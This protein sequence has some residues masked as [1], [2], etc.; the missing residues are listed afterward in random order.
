MAAKQNSMIPIVSKN[1]CSA[2]EVVLGVRMRP[3]V[4]NGGG[5]VVIDVT[6]K[7]VFRVDG[8]GVIGKKEQLLLRDGDGNELLLI[9][10][11]GGI[12]EAL[13]LHKRW[14]GYSHDL[15]G[16][17]KLVFSL[18]EPKNSYSCMGKNNRITVSVA[19]EYSA[20]GEFAI[21]GEFAA[22]DCYI[23]N[24]NGSVIAQVSIYDSF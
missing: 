20:Y 10:R 24:S 9:R 15:E 1:F 5:F 14:K 4:V 13:S 17:E 18:K 16:S 8:C 22:R 6:Q 21:T 7:V 11:K 2:S 19:S 12:V 3:N 23:V